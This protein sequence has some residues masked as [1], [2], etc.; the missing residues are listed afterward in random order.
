MNN[1]IARFF[2]RNV[3]ANTGS[4]ERLEQPLRKALVL[5]LDFELTG[6]D[7]ERAHITSVGWVEGTGVEIFPATSFYRTVK[8]TRS[9]EQ[10]PVIHGLTAP[11]IEKGQP[12]RKITQRLYPLISTHII[13]CHHARLEQGMLVKLAASF[14]VQSCNLII[15]D[16]LQVARYLLQKQG[17]VISH[18]SLKL[19]VCRSR[20][21]LPDAPQHNALADA[22]ACYELWLAQAC[23]LGIT[24][25]DAISALSHTGGVV[26]KK[27]GKKHR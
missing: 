16:T 19:S 15:I 21:S 4:D 10:S 6:L 5:A 3:V 22:Q 12:I 14:G 11:V 27:I 13:I 7:P 2:G 25:D 26:V 9:L 17:S 23:E 1:W 18:D 20:Y 8:T 24:P